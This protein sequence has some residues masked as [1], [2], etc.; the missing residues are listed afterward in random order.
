MKS[1]R[2]IILA[3]SSFI[4]V[5]VLVSFG[6]A[7]F[8]GANVAFWT[9]SL[10]WSLLSSLIVMPA[11]V[12]VSLASDE[13]SKKSARQAPSKQEPFIQEDSDE[14]HTLWP[15]PEQKAEWPAQEGER[16]RIHA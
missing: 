9:S 10:M 1:V 5:W 3:L 11:L 15:E 13:A 14:A 2:R 16:E 7:M 8:D 6:G 12:M 4:G